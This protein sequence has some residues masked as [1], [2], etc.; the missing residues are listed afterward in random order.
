MNIICCIC[1]KSFLK[2]RIFYS[3]SIFGL[4]SPSW[5]QVSDRLSISQM[6]CAERFQ[7]QNH[8]LLVFVFLGVKP[9]ASCPIG[10]YST[11]YIS[12][13]HLLLILQHV[14]VNVYL[15]IHTHIYILAELYFTFLL[16]LSYIGR[17]TPI[18]FGIAHKGNEWVPLKTHTSQSSYWPCDSKMHC[19]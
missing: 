3:L 13:F 4:M 9:R 12:S 11:K 15:S 1:Y 8:P 18:R 5:P 16:L 10:Q 2:K 19:S 6:W 7:A 17:E 14:Y